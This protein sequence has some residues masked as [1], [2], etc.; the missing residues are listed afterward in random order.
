MII[1]P[2]I[3]IRDRVFINHTYSQMPSEEG[4]FY[5]FVED[6]YKYIV[7]LLDDMTIEEF[8]TINTIN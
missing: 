4:M 8:I 5:L 1:K 3:Q 6:K 2:K 7:E